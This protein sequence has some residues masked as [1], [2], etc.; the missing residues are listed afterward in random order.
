MPTLAQTLSFQDGRLYLWR[1]Y[2]T[3]LS[4]QVYKLWPSPREPAVLGDSEEAKKEYVE[5][6]EMEE[7]SK[8]I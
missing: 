1:N 4:Y 2:Y 7:T 8:C 6:S 3:T 5:K